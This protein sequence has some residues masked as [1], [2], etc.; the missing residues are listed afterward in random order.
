MIFLPIGTDRRQ[1][2][3]PWV[4]WTLVAL[5]VAIFVA[6]RRRVED[7]F[8]ENI[9]AF[10]FDPLH[11]AL[12]QFLSYQFLHGSWAHLIGNMI[13]LYVFGNNLE[14]R[15][16]KAAYLGFYLSGGVL[17]ALGHGLMET[18]PVLGASGAVAAVSGAYLALFPLANVTIAYWFMF[19]GFFEVS[20]LYLIGFYIVMNVYNHLTGGGQVAYLAHLVGYAY[21]FG[22]GMGLLRVGLLTREPYDF[23]SIV[24]H[25]RRRAQFATLARQ[26]YQPWQSPPSN[27]SSTTSS[28][29]GK[30]LTE[31][32][33][34]ALGLRSQIAQAAAAGNLAWA[35]DLYGRLL[36][37]APQAV[38]NQQ[39]QLD[40]ANQLMSAAHYPQAAR[41]YE[42]FLG[43]YSAYPQREQIELILGLIYARYLHNAPRARDLLTASL[44][45]LSDSHQHRLA[46]ETLAQLPA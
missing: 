32:E 9:R 4:N 26:G 46:E 16:G 18:T 14:D 7:P 22:I 1:I 8:D 39:Q 40:V 31:Q 33:K 38:L 34:Q 2:H 43:C 25:R 3:R 30:E 19:L 15:L 5:N 41:A 27:A 42:L 24:E 45:R 13:F 37:L 44:R 12:Y 28:P 17:A 36:E 23:L 6:T 29:P 10:L 11:P 20:S 35:A 21:G